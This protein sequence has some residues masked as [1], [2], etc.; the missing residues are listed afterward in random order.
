MSNAKRYRRRH[1]DVQ[2]FA[3]AL[4]RFLDVCQSS[5][6]DPLGVFYPSWTPKPGREAEAT[7]L[8]SE[9]D[10]V[11]GRAAVA[12]GYEFFIDWKPRGTMK[13]QRVNP[14]A[15][16]RT[17]LDTDPFFPVDAIFAV[18]NQALGVLDMRATEAEEDEKSLA[19][20]VGR[21]AGVRRKRQPARKG[22]S[23]G[24]PLR[25]AFIASIA[26]IPSLLVVAYLVF[27]FGWV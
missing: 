23:G 3:L 21:V 19:G 12:L 1:D 10:R 16:W 2:A 22:E 8:A 6:G 27:R 17:I 7:R 25:S 26:S 9:V 20:K 14:A 4:A 11:A 5:G 15:G 18:C 24:G 13:T